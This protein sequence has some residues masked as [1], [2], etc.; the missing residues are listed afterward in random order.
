MCDTGIGPAVA[1]GRTVDMLNGGKGIKTRADVTVFT[2]DHCY[3]EATRTEIFAEM[4]KVSTIEHGGMLQHPEQLV[5]KCNRCVNT[6]DGSTGTMR[7]LTFEVLFKLAAVRMCERSD[8]L[9]RNMF[10][11]QNPE[12][13]ASFRTPA[14]LQH[15]AEWE[16]EEE[17]SAEPHRHRR[18]S[19]SGCSYVGEG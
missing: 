13:Y 15:A 4:A 6:D 12:E 3:R 10:R 16:Q 11:L 7:I 8:K 19:V 18:R 5:F 1:C 2:C 17:A 14:Q 9:G